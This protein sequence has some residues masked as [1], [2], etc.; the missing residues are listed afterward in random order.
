[1]NGNGCECALFEDIGICTASATL[2]GWPCASIYQ[3][4]VV[5]AEFE[6]DG[7]ITGVYKFPEFRNLLIHEPPIELEVPDTRRSANVGDT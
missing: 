6:D 5:V 3:R 2:I 4:A 1:M 7:S